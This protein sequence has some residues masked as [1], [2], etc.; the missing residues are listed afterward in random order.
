M[1]EEPEITFEQFEMLRRCTFSRRVFAPY[2][3]PA[4]LANWH[5]SRGCS[6]TRSLIAC[7]VGLSLAGVSCE[8]AEGGLLPDDSDLN[9]L[10]EALKTGDAQSRKNAAKTLGKMKAKSA[11]AVPSLIA[12]VA[13]KDESVRSA[14]I[15]A[16]AD[17]GAKLDEVIPVFSRALDDEAWVVRYSQGVPRDARTAFE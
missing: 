4:I 5:H 8:S 15:Y 3:G 2:L 7:L 12:S 10:L 14:V 1:A 17:I 16:L 9:R 6:M 13:D 11:L